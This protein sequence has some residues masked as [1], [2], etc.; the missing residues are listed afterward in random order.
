MLQI[1]ELRNQGGPAIAMERL[2][3]MPEDASERENR[4]FWIN[5]ED[6]E[7]AEIKYIA[8]LFGL[9]EDFFSDPLDPAERPRASHVG[10]ATLIIARSSHHPEQEA[11]GAEPPERAEQNYPTAPVGMV[12]IKNVTLTICRVPGL[13]DEL[14]AGK[15]PVGKARQHPCI[16]LKLLEKISTRF[17]K[18]LQKLDEISNRIE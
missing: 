3:Q 15:I 7:T 11:D 17:I 6:P 1:F 16:V 12:L 13:V 8:D 4:E 5:L 2:P 9:P 18:H 10:E 14:C